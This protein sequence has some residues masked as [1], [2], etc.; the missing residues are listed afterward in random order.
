MK[1]NS[2]FFFFDMHAYINNYYMKLFF[3]S[4]NKLL[5]TDTFQIILFIKAIHKKKKKR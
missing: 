1:L 2:F 5:I 4:Y 3:Y